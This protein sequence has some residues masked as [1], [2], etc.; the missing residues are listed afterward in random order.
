MYLAKAAYQRFVTTIY[1]LQY[2]YALFFIVIGLDRFFQF[3]GAAWD[4]YLSAALTQTVPVP[5]SLIVAV[6]A[7][8]HLVAGVALL[9][10][11]LCRLGAS[12]GFIML[13]AI[14]IDLILADGG[15]FYVRASLYA[16]MAVGILALY[17]LWIIRDTLEKS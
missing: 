13:L 14:A 5:D 4:A 9:M 6:I 1:M 16:V 11:Y 17:N 12:I 7:I 15:E 2:T 10:P 3:S 8:G